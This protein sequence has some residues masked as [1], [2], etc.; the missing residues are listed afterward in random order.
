MSLNLISGGSSNE[1]QYVTSRRFRYLFIYNVVC[2]LLLL[3]FWPFHDLC[4]TPTIQA[5]LVILNMFTSY[6]LFFVF[7]M[8][9]SV[10][11]KMYIF[12]SWGVWFSSLST[13]Y[14][15]P[16]LLGRKAQ[17]FVTNGPGNGPVNF[18][19]WGGQFDI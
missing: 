18:W 4:R 16:D 10:I 14:L 11:D 3:S 9:F 17:T 5:I 12:I 7:L 6:I 8:F 2:I 19:S 1:Y 13:V 15:L